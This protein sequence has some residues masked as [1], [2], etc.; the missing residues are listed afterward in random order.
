M[1]NMVALL[2][3]HGANPCQQNATGWS[4]LHSAA[5]RGNP[6]IIK[7]LL[8]GDICDI[9]IANSK[10]K[11]PL[12][13]AV[14]E[15][16]LQIIRFS[17]LLLFCQSFFTEHSDLSSVADLGFPRG[18]GANPKG[19]GHERIIWP[20]FPENCMKTKKFWARGGARPSRPLPLDPSLELISSK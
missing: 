20:I 11:T 19:G 7:S 17:T 14:E 13:V 3:S 1:F 8:E 4:S 6:D 18:A 2:L 5:K 9:N 10:G 15:N 12:M 16:K